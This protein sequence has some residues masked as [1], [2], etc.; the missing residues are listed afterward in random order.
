MSFIPVPNQ[1]QIQT[2]LRGFLVGILPNSVQIIEGQDNRVS[3]PSVDDF[4]V[5]TT[6]RRERI[7]T[8][9]DTSNDCAFTASISGTV[10]TVTNME[11]GKIA[12]GNLLFGIGVAAGTVIS[13][14]GT[15]SGGAGTYIV[16]ISQTVSGELMASGT[17]NDLQPTRVTVQ[18]DV[19]GPH[20]A[21]NAQTISTLFR[22]DF[23][24]LAFLASGYDVRPLYADDP[25]QVPFL[26]AEQAYE[27]R[28][29]VEAVL[30]ANQ[31]IA[32]PQQYAQQIQVTLESVDARFPH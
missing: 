23:G 10:L 17:Q 2:A 6:I 28:W 7:E 31:V 19:H 13:G 25:K 11:L 14:A 21:D 15:G 18:L 27:T 20:S 1:S 26:N 9:I 12:I 3:E 29:I 32:P 5:M 24:T 22:D 4:V 16:S 30:Q 8:N